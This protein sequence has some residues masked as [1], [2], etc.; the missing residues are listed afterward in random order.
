[1]TTITVTAADT[2]QAMDKIVERL[3]EDALILET[4]KRNGRIEMIATDSAEETETQVPVTGATQTS[5][6]A[7][8]AVNI[9]IGSEAGFTDLFDQQMIKTVKD[10]ART[11][12]SAVDHLVGR[13]IAA[14]DNLEIVTELRS[15]RQ[16]LNGMMITHPEGLEVTLGHAAPVHFTRQDSPQRQFRSFMGTWLG[17]TL[18]MRS[19]PLSTPLQTG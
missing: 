8:P 7:A 6:K 13:T 14:S 15:I 3:G 16:M 19:L 1:M 12:A 9:E 10:S 5:A 18:K 2:A 17:L 11:S 4:V